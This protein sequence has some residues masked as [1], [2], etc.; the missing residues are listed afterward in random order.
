MT[1]ETSV[2]KKGRL[3]LT[4]AFLIEYHMYGKYNSAS[5]IVIAVGSQIYHKLF[6]LKIHFQKN[7]KASQGGPTH[8]PVVQN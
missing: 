6:I 8:Q 5:I 4:C 1:Q 7:F 2:T 3:D